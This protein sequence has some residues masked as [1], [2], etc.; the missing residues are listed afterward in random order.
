MMPSWVFTWVFTVYTVQLLAIGYMVPA[1][2]GR[3]PTI[4]VWLQYNVILTDFWWQPVF[5]KL[6]STSFFEIFSNLRFLFYFIFFVFWP[7]PLTKCLC[8]GF[9]DE[10]NNSIRVLNQ[11]SFGSP[12]ADVV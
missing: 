2:H 1:L 10:T 9:F 12:F 8:C 4:T 5:S 7:F 3:T 11:A 6:L